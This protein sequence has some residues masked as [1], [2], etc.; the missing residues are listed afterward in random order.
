MG[1]IVARSAAGS[2]PGAPAHGDGG[3]RSA[4][5]ARRPLAT[6]LVALAAVLAAALPASADDLDV[7][8]ARL[9]KQKK[10][11]I[12][13]VLDY[14]G[15]MRQDIHGEEIAPGSGTPAKIELLREAMS[16]VLAANTD[17]INAGLGS[18]FGSRPSGVRWPI[19][20]LDADPSTVD[21]AIVPGSRTMAQV[22]EGQLVRQDAGG[23]TLT[24]NALVEAAQY[25]GG[26]AVLNGGQDP[27][28]PSGHRPDAWD[29]ATGAYA[30]GSSRAAIGAAYSTVPG[31]GP[32]AGYALGAG[33]PGDFGWCNDLSISGGP[34]A[35]AGLVTYDCVDQAAGTW[36]T[37][38]D[39][40]TSDARR[41]CKY[42]HPDAWRGATYDSP[43][44]QSCQANAIVLISDGEPDPAQRNGA[45]DA[46]IGA[47]ECEDLSASVFDSAPGTAVDGNCGPEVVR[48]LAT[49]PQDPTLPDSTVRTYTVGFDVEGPGKTY[50]QRLASDG[51]GAYFD[52]EAPGDLSRAL[53]SIVDDVA[54]GAESFAEL[55]IGVNRETFSSDDRAFASLFA[56]SLRRGWNG[57][58]KG[59]FLD[60]DG[61]VDLDGRPATGADGGFADGARSFWSAV[62][63]GDTVE[64]GGA[65]GKLD[66]TARNLY[67]DAGDGSDHGDALAG[68][69]ANVIGSTNG[70]ITA[71]DLGLP[72][73]SPARG[74]VLDWL[75]AAPMGDPLH[76]KS[77]GVDYGDRQ[78]VYV[79]TNQGLLHAIDATAPTAPG[80]GAAGSGNDDGGRELFAYMPRRLLANL[81]ALAS[82]EIGE[83]HVYGLDGSITRWHEDDDGDGVVDAGES[84]LLVL[85]MRRGGTAYHAIDVSDPTSP[86]LEWV[87]DDASPGFAKLAQTWSRASLLEVRRGAGTERVLAFG[88]GYDADRLDGR[89][90]R[91]NA[92]GDAVFL[93]DRDGDL[94]RR[95]DGAGMKHSI[96]ADLTAIDSDVDGLADRIY[97]ADVGGRIWR[98]D[99]DDP[100]ASAGTI[101]RFADLHSNAAPQPL[102][103][104]PSVALVRS[105]ARPFLSVS[106]GSGDRTDPLDAASRNAL[107]MLRDRDVAKGPPARGT[108]RIDV[109]DLHDATGDALGSSDPV[110]AAAAR[111]ALDAARGWRV[112][113]AVGEKV[114]AR[115][116]SFE[117][118]LL[119]TSYRPEDDPSADPCEYAE[120]RRFHVLDI[121]TAR[122]ADTERGGVAASGT[123]RSETLGG[124]GIPPTPVI[125]HPK[126]SGQAD[127]IIDK[128]VTKSFDKRVKRVYWHAR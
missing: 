1:W 91:R 32:K 117:G 123:P 63:D 105:G 65:S 31:D 114:L 5:R 11:N 100:W 34:N 49:T 116:V 50:L 97:A 4:R 122:A 18:L 8:R 15:S 111:T 2:A 36:S 93:V 72:D 118:A 89:D 40:G 55:S 107:F 41:T 56:P 45:L 33:E 57:N 64:A 19:A 83:D 79:M 48:A 20:P 88:G 44:A 124:T 7:Y 76:S 26:R 77:V 27:R 92:D 84:L 6:G 125:V 99:F 60:A 12:L 68:S 106:I 73:G 81:P 70:S 82:G 22:I 52:A 54:F 35:C 3:D 21:P 119:A 39:E 94:V 30:G 126:G 102:F 103:S 53:Q 127:S 14:S 9:A 28:Q 29:P 59:Y 128:K 80:D 104:A 23:S 115:T 113:L 25:F 46:L 51:G 78:V 47:G 38:G 120:E 71:A 16:E 121:A 108:T 98:I 42:V 13:F 61:L 43:I 62:P 69:E 58:L 75:R 112:D 17:T 90:K 109:D 37:E 66:P 95:F 101:T 10:P 86:R 110:V 74:P 87:V 24:V 67:T 85:G 96:A